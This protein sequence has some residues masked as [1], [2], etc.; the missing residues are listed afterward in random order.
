MPPFVHILHPQMASQRS[1]RVP[2][3]VEWMQIAIEQCSP[4]ALGQAHGVLRDL[5][6]R[7]VGHTQQFEHQAAHFDESLDEVL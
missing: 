7:Q 3:S 5:G 2:N 4:L 1:G 6:R